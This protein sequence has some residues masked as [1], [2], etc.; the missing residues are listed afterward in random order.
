MSVVSCPRSRLRS[1][2]VKLLRSCVTWFSTVSRV[3]NTTVVRGILGSATLN[4]RAYT[5]SLPS[6]R[7]ALRG[8]TAVCVPNHSEKSRVSGAN[9]TGSRVDPHTTANGA[10]STQKSPRTVPFRQG[11][12]LRESSCTAPPRIGMDN[13]PGLYRSGSRSF[14]EAT[15][16]RVKLLL[17]AMA[18]GGVLPV[19]YIPYG[20]CAAPGEMRCSSDG[21]APVPSSSIA[22]HWTPDIGREDR[23]TL[24]L[25]SHTTCTFPTRSSIP[26]EAR[27]PSCAPWTNSVT[28]AHPHHGAYPRTNT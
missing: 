7:S 28:G 24:P 16:G 1:P 6:I 14:C 21:K 10:L 27:L 26:T 8:M 17:K 15:K 23:T 9:N 25:H 12:M 13:A 4:L 2:R 5:L 11:P 22:D 3:A 19:V 20:G 18:N